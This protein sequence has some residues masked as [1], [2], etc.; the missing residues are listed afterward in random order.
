[1]DWK[2]VSWKCLI[3]I[4]GIAIPLCS[5]HIWIELHIIVLSNRSNI[6]PNQLT[7][8]HTMPHFDTLKIYIAVENIVTKGEIACSKQF[9]LFSQSFLP[10]MALIFRFKF[11]LICHLLFGPV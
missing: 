4:Y 7:H 11:T 10:Y 5:Q 6:I 1:M 3:Q 8:Y 9:L 2:S